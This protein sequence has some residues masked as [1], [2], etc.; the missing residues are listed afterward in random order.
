MTEIKWWAETGSMKGITNAQQLQALELGWR[1]I[2]EVCNVKF[3]RVNSRSQAKFWIEFVPSSEIN[4]SLGRRNGN[5]IRINRDRDINL[6]GVWHLKD[7]N[8]K[9]RYVM[10]L[11]IHEFLHTISLGHTSHTRTCLMHA[12]QGFWL[13]PDSVKRLQEKYGAPSKTF[14]P[15]QKQYIG[16]QIRDLV[17]TRKDLQQEREDLITQRDGSTVKSFRQAT[18]KKVLANLKLLVANHHSLA[19]KS[20]EWHQVNNTWKNTPKAG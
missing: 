13:C 6:D 11:S 3:I 7:D 1:E 9:N 15:R 8:I 14:Y 2:E 4:G 10:A 16:T 17:A 5:R 20:K 19:A 12:W 18:Q